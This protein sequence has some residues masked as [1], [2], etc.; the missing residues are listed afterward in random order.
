MSL[1]RRLQEIFSID[2]DAHVEPRFVAI[3]K[4]YDEHEKQNDPEKKEERAEL[5]AILQVCV[6][7]QPRPLHALV[8][9]HTTMRMARSL[10]RTFKDVIVHVP[11][12]L[13]YT[14]SKSIQKRHP[15]IMLYQA[16]VHTFLKRAVDELAF[17]NV[18]PHDY[19]FVW[20]DTCGSANHE[21][22]RTID[23]LFESASFSQAGLSVLAITCSHRDKTNFI[24]RAI[25]ELQN[26]YFYKRCIVSGFVEECG[27]INDY[28]VFKPTRLTLPR[29]KN[30]VYTIVYCVCP[31]LYY[32]KKSKQE[33]IQLEEEFSDA[34]LGWRPYDYPSF[35]VPMYEAGDDDFE[36]S[37]KK[38]RL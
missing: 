12:P 13:A 23:M 8:L 37:A 33:R 6:E 27:R 1:S 30:G 38:R 34:L 18:V 29:T 17:N 9:D 31:F 7:D 24:K 14:L 26:F 35:T 5:K 10:T 20:I 15:N 19:S 25:R 22:Y 36:K 11:H 28:F 2:P 21:L 16:D 4:S 32:M 3:H